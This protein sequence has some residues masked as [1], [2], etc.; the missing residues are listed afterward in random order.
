MAKTF[1]PTFSSAVKVSPS[2]SPPASI[3]KGSEPFFQPTSSGRTGMNFSV[4]ISQP[5]SQSRILTS[6]QSALEK[7]PLL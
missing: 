3:A 4:S 7:T 5:A 2:H 1:Q 6:F